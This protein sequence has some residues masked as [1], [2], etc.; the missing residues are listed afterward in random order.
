MVPLNESVDNLLL[1]D[2]SSDEVESSKTLPATGKKQLITQP[3]P[4]NSS[5]SSSLPPDQQQLLIALKLP[6]GSRVEQCFNPSDTPNTVL[7]FVYSYRPGVVGGPGM[8]DLYGVDKTCKKLYD[9]KLT[10]AQLGVLDRSLLYVE[11]N[12]YE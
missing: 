9:R 11:R 12:D 6:D 10:L 8:C 3:P 7:L 2:S 4:P 1:S 5:S